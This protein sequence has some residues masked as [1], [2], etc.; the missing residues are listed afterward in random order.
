[1]NQL[2]I[3]RLFTIVLLAFLPL[4]MNSCKKDNDA[5]P[6]GAAGTW[7]LDAIT[8][9]PGLKVTGV[10][11][12]TDYTATAKGL[13]DNCANDLRVTFNTAGT[14]TLNSPTTCTPA[15]SPIGSL[16]SDLNNAKWVQSGS[17]LT[18]TYSDNT[19]ETFNYSLSGN[20]M[21]LS[22]AANFNGDG[23]NITLTIQFSRV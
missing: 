22:E 20:V 4:W 3:S 10:G 18:V 14:I 6:A 9:N 11:T 21:K 17:T 7:K 8:F 1:M 16:L 13:G 23:V 19:T 2:N 15:T 12:I 5:E